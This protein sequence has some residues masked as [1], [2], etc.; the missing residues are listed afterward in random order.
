VEEAGGKISDYNGRTWSPESIDLVATN[1]QL[2][3]HI[4]AVTKKERPTR[5]V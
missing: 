4:I 2:H 3:P 1:K 5:A